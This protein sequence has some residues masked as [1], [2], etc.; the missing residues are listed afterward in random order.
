M[1]EETK[2][3]P[4]CGEEI[5]A[6]A[7]KCKHCGSDL[8]KATNPAQE[9]KMAEVDYGL[10][11]PLSIW[12]VHKVK[13]PESFGG[14]KTWTYRLLG[15]LSL[16]WMVGLP[17]FLF[18][19]GSKK[20]PIRRTQAKNF[21]ISAAIGFVFW[22]AFVASN[23][24]ADPYGYVDIVK[25]GH[26]SEYPDVTVG[27]AVDGFF[28]NPK[29]ESGES[30]SGI[31]FVN[32]KGGIEVM[33]QPAEAALQFVV[34]DEDGTFEVYALDINDEGQPPIMMIGVLGAMFEAN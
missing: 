26:L 16:G 30:E 31:K 12:N 20:T 28:K 6:V 9:Q 5:L 24:F 10:E 17:L 8:G 15:L 14:F 27:E 4:M 2:R 22:L 3:C 34:D 33:G 21:L 13:N 18:N 19:N 7:V 11:K 1:A 29:W 25:N 23:P 32:V